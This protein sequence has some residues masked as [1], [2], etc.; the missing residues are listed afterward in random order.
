MTRLVFIPEF[1]ADG[2]EC[3]KCNVPL[4]TREDAVEFRCEYVGNMLRAEKAAGA[5]LTD[6]E[7]A[8]LAEIDALKE[9]DVVSDVDAEAL[10]ILARMDKGGMATAVSEKYSEALAALASPFSEPGSPERAELKAKVD[11]P[12][13]VGARK[14]EASAEN[15]V[16][17]DSS[18]DGLRRMLSGV[19]GSAAPKPLAS[20][21]GERL[22]NELLALVTA[23]N[24]EEHMRSRMVQ[25]LREIQVLMDRTRMMAKS[26]GWENVDIELANVHDFL[27]RAISAAEQ[28]K[29]RDIRKKG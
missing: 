14:I 1:K 21:H 11:G 23:K 2:H 25:S 13:G 18:A 5:P 28:V 6:A 29:A 17:D 27:G 7:L 8:A 26:F 12:W 24:P 22:V 9:S 20:E 4:M 10:E 3:S 16:S 19:I 15:S